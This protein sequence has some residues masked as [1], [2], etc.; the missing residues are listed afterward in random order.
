MR[1]R[2]RAIVNRSSGLDRKA[3]IPFAKKTANPPYRQIRSPHFLLAFHNSVIGTSSKFSI[4]MKSSNLTFCGS[5]FVL[6]LT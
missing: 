2:R 1:H 4:I 5:L 6:L 3:S